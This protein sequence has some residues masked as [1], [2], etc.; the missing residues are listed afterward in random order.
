MAFP[1][2]AFT[3]TVKTCI[4]YPTDKHKLPSPPLAIPIHGLDLLGPPINIHNH[5]F[6]EPLQQPL[7]LIVEKLKSSLAEAL[8]LYPPVAGT[9][10]ANEK[11]EIYISTEAVGTPFIIEVK[12]TPYVGDSESLSPQNMVSIPLLSPSLAVK[13]TQV[14]A[15]L[16]KYIKFIYS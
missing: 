4:V 2:S 14:S 8:E 16:L 15:L 3:M 13:V 9:V 6:Y 7:T 5:R 1:V 10:K 11:G 12:N